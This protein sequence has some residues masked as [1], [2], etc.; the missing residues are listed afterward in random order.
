LKGVALRRGFGGVEA[1]GVL[2]DVGDVGIAEAC[3][4]FEETLMWWHG[5]QAYKL[6]V[7]RSWVVSG[8]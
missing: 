4:R 6:L 3:G 8:A 2:D 7:W 1:G 5:R